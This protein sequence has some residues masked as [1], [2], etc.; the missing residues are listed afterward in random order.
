[1][2][3]LLILWVLIGH[4]SVAQTR[5]EKNVSVNPGQKV[6]M[7][8]K[9]PELISVKTWDRNEIKISAEVSINFGRNDESFQFEIDEGETLRINSIIENY[10]ELPRNIVIRYQGEDYFFET[11]DPHSPEIMRFREEIG[12]SGYEYMRHGVIMDI[13]VDVIVPKNIALNVDAK[14]GLIEVEGFTDKI[15][16]SSKFGGI[17]VRVPQT[18]PSMKVR[19]KFGEVY[20]NLDME[21]SSRDRYEIGRWVTLEGKGSNPSNPQ[22]FRSEFGNVYLRKM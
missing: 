19:T 20:S 16:V 12:D 6:E 14:F 4:A 9:H 21:F 13:K 15:E 5:V 18:N 1:M 2:R 10:S 11:K 17:D 3:Y 8:F 7:Y 22:Y